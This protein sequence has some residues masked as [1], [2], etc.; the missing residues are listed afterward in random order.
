ML[1]LTIDLESSAELLGT[2]PE[3]FLGFVEQQQLEG[4]LKFKDGWRVSIF[5][6]AKVL[7]TSTQNL[8]NVLEDAV[9][10]KLLE[11]VEDN[12]RLGSWIK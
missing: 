9:L 3:T 4:V 11:E 8:L 2:R 7:N 6:L 10:G 12:E 1:R 5:T